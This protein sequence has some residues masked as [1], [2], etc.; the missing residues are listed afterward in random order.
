MVETDVLMHPF[1][2]GYDAKLAV[3]SEYDNPLDA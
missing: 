3:L 1:N 2:Q